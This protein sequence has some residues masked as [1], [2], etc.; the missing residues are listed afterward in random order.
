MKS[1]YGGSLEAASVRRKGAHRWLISTRRSMS[2]AD[3]TN[4]SN[5]RDR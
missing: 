2:F 1:E 5:S 3:C 4:E